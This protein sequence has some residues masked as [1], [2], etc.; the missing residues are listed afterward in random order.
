MVVVR[1]GSHNMAI[2]DNVRYYVVTQECWHIPDQDVHF[3]KGDIVVIT[4]TSFSNLWRLE[5]KKLK[6]VVSSFDYSTLIKYYARRLTNVPMA[7]AI[8]G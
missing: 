8:Y 2:A 3:Q 4:R 5:H 7:D 1:R 6:Y